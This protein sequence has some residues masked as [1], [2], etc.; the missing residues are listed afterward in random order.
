M[1]I[2]TLIATGLAALVAAAGASAAPRVGHGVVY[3]FFGQL[4]AA[5]ANGQVSISVQAGNR[6]ALRAML[7]Q[8]VAQTFAYADTTE[9]L[10]W[11]AGIPTIVQ[12]GGLSAGDYV[13]VHVRA[14]EGASLA[15]VEKQSAG[16]IGD[17]GTQVTPPAQP[18]YEF[19]GTLTATG[20]NTVTLDVTGGNARA[21]RLLIGQPA[22]ETF[23]TGSG[24]IFLLWQGKVPTV[25]SLGQLKVGDRVVVRVH[26]D[27][28][29]TLAQ[30]ESAAAVHV[31]D[32]EPASKS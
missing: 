32:R 3:S 19:R 1:R 16:L 5:P 14:A 11:S 2:A 15:D 4:S 22:T 10:Q 27:K 20:T 9:F 6:R 7:G 8:P 26:A 17:H 25:I 23:T 12:A 30:V 13:W 28:G 21:G 29:S 31:G 18:L 24:T